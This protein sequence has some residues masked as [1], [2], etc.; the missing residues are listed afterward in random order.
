MNFQLQCD[1]P[2]THRSKSNQ[3]GLMSLLS[4]L[5]KMYGCSVFMDKAIKVT[6]LYGDGYT[7][8]HR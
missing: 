3:T 6:S 4:I 1:I 2:K 5:Y 7:N 8:G